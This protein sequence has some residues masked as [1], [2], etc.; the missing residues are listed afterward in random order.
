MAAAAIGIFL[1]DQLSKSLVRATMAL[2]ESRQV[3]GEALRLTYIMNPHGLMG[4]SF[5]PAGRYLMLPL[6]LAAV[7]A[8]IY[9]YARWQRRGHLPAATLGMLL[10]GAAGN[11]LDRLRLGAVVDFIDCDIPDVRI[12]AFDL[13]PIHYPGLMLDRWYTFNLADSSVL[14]GVIVLFILT[15][16]GERQGKPEGI[17]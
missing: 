17:G 16:H 10:A 11:M 13:G 7:A 8:I 9:F 3:L 12:P 1:A 4:F 2:G 5:G 14:I 6:S 15:L